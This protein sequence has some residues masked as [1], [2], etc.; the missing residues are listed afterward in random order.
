VRIRLRSTDFELGAG[1]LSLTRAGDCMSR[2]YKRDER[3]DV[4]VY[5]WM[6]PPPPDEFAQPTGSPWLVG[7]LVAERYDAKD[8]DG[9][10]QVV[11]TI[12]IMISADVQSESPP[13]VMVDLLAM[14]E[15]WHSMVGSQLSLFDGG[16]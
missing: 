8:F 9:G 3:Q 16:L 14:R 5:R 10:I 4:H 2:K 11:A 7:E 15:G 13:D 6:T 1:P 12:T